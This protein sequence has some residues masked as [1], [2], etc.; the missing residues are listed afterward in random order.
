MISA[1]QNLAKIVGADGCY[2]LS[3]VYIAELIANRPFP[4]LE[5]IRKGQRLGFI[6]PETTVLDAGAFVSDLTMQKWS[7]TKSGPGHPLPLD[8]KIQSNEYEILRFE[9]P[10]PKGGDPL[11][12]FV[13]GAGDGFTVLFDPWENSLTVQYGH[14]VSRRIFRRA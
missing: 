9:R 8:Y 5:S 13:V 14:I 2:A 7:C 3:C 12:H 4:A 1:I 6:D 11:P 10:S